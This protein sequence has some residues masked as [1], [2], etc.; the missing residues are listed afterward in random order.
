MS[1]VSAK[2][3]LCFDFDFISVSFPAAVAKP[4]A[5]LPEVAFPDAGQQTH[6]SLFAGHESYVVCPDKD[7]V[8]VTS[9]QSV[10]YAW[11]KRQLR[12]NY[13]WKEKQQLLLPL[14][15]PVP[16]SLHHQDRF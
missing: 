7:P 9:H 14:H 5:A 16:A 13:S 1:S 4:L 10:S 12:I 2:Y 11:P 8:K 6:S 15:L 3:L